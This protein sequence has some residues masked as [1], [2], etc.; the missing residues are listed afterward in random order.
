MIRRTLFHFGWS[1]A[2]LALVG[3]AGWI[4][5]S[6]MGRYG[7]A[8][9]RK[10]LTTLASTA[11]AAIEGD[12][13]AKLKGGSGDIGTP[14]FQEVRDEL[15][16]IHGAVPEMRFVYLMTER[17]GAWLFLADAEDVGSPDYSPPGQ[18]YDGDTGVLR[19]VLRSG[20]A[21]FDGPERDA[22]GVWVSGLAPIVGPDQKPI[23][24][25][26]MDIRAND[27]LTRI[28][29]YRLFGEAIAGL[30]TTVVALFL[31]GLYLQSAHLVKLQA[32]I[33]ER[34]RANEAVRR[35]MSELE[36]A[37]RLAHLGSWTWEP[38]KDRVE[39]STE[40]YRMTGY[41]PNLPA[42]S[43]ADQ[44]R[45]LT[46]ESYERLMAAADRCLRYDAPYE[47]EL[48]FRRPDGPGGWMLARGEVEPEKG[49][50]PRFLRGTAL[51]I[52]DRKRAET[53]VARWMRQDILT[54][55]ANRSVFVAALER[56]ITQV[57]RGA[58][59]F[60]VLYLDLDHFK[61]I[62]DTLGHPAG[63]QLLQRVA[64]R[65]RT[66]MRDAD[67]LARFGGDEFAL[68]VSQLGDHED[69]AV[70]AKK[71]ISSIAE[72]IPIQ[73]IDVRTTVSIGIAVC[74]S[75][76]TDAEALLSHADLALYEAKSRGRGTYQFFTELMDSKARAR[77][78]L[79][80]DLRVA[81]HLRQLFLL[82]QPQVDVQTGQ[83]IGA[84]ALVYWQHPER[85]I[86][87][88][89]EFIPIAEKT[90]LI[91]PLGRWVLEESCRQMKEWLDLGIA[92]RFV[93]VNL[94]GVQLQRPL[95]LEQDIYQTLHKTGL[96]AGRLE[97]ELTETVLME[98]SREHNDVL[99]RLREQ[100][101]RIAIDDFGTGYSSLDYLRRFPVDRIK[102]AQNFLADLGAG[103]ENA[104]IVKAAIG[105]AH[106][107][108]LEVVVEGVETAE[109]AALISS[110]GCREIQGYYLSKPLPADGMRALLRQGVVYAIGTELAVGAEAARS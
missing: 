36:E 38:A 7:E 92:P 12:L 107:L 44:V 17:N 13:V 102:I 86:V 96:P 110:W 1:A 50:K 83:I 60:A 42:P 9:E 98:A 77:V 73:G 51:E 106:S 6:S 31:A 15:R 66:S 71:L 19:S 56:A 79:S 88:P 26:G 81:I 49:S 104:V 76:D 59:G 91:I 4:L 105:L 109:Q 53:Q 40:L 55:L 39:W 97:L 16:R 52:T 84:E 90:G 34:Q 48:E 41:D 29:H 37:Q 63:D 89:A 24:V 72:P 47:L 82:Y 57:R 100:G 18:A 45:L 62:N 5:V 68:I 95:E 28:D 8:L 70:V 74:A 75:G 99:L 78:A 65:L 43:V 14:P 54:G 85:G 27:W 11:A 103:S 30:V 46:P 33:A 58:P 21:A 32:E 67:T 22:W 87:L 61:D 69:A 94:S 2:I 35:S 3:F 93:A 20:R 25:L 64:Q 23:A 101:L 10:N 108:N 80:T